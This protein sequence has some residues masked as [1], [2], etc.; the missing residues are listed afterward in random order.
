VLLLG[1][2]RIRRRWQGMR[3]MRK[4]GKFTFVRGISNKAKNSSVLFTLG[5][6]FFM[7]AF[8]YFLGK[9]TLLERA[10]TTVM[11]LV[12]L[13]LIF[14]SIIFLIKI[15]IGGDAFRI[16]I[17][18]KVVAYF[19]REMYLFYFTGLRRIE[20]HQDMINFQYKGDLNL[21]LPLEILKKED[22]A[23]FRDALIETLEAY[24]VSK[25]GRVIYID[26]AF[27]KLA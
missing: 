14:E 27:R 5:E 6:L 18:K 16:G 26:E 11:L 25:N 23:A 2:V 9:M 3:D 21:F 1:L 17:N 4:F 15:F 8:F 20:I 7:L 24:A 22:R 12:M 19:N 13:I 10:Y